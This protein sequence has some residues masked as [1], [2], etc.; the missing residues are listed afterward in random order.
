MTLRRIV[1]LEIST[2]EMTC[3]CACSVTSSTFFRGFWLE[4][5][6][7]SIDPLAFIVDRILR[8]SSIRCTFGSLLHPGQLLSTWPVYF[9]VS[10]GISDDSDKEDIRVRMHKYCTR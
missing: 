1:P 5:T 7:P 3:Q 9:A 10:G 4:M 2:A 8:V 6:A